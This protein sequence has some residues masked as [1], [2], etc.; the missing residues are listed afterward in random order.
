MNIDLFRPFIAPE[1]A[2]MLASLF[3]PDTDGRL[4]IGQGPRADDLERK[5]GHL[6]EAPYPPLSMASCTAALDMAYEL[7]GI[8]PSSEVITTPITC[9]ATNTNLV[10]R[11]ARLVWADVNPTTGCIDPSDVA[12]K[13]TS[14]TKAIVAVDWAGRS[15]DYAALRR[16]DVPVVEDAAHALL[17]RTKEG[18]IANSGGD[19]VCWSLGPIKHL[20][21]GDGGMLLT[22]KDQHERARLL[23]WYGLDRR[24]SKDF[25]CDQE[26]NEAGTKSHM[27]DI[28]ATIALANL[29]HA[30]R[31][32]SAHRSNA[33]KLHDA[34]DG[35][36]GLTL[37]PFDPYSAH[38]IFTLLVEHRDAF[39]AHMA[40]K[41]IQ[42]SRVHARN[43]KHK[44]LADAGSRNKLPNVVFFDQ[45][46][47]S[48]PCGWWLT[49]ADIEHIL[50][51]VHAWK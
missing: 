6:V 20:S 13:V 4:F 11:G 28:N 12:R 2:T 44:A 37:L 48:L 3:T 23:R 47:V 29:P 34:L 38:W 19:Y 27:N 5:F 35:T 21:G 30:K 41:G 31:I 32:V 24:C 14:R 8:G 45:H 51:A 18:S 39:M 16:H 22:P 43:D 15:C 7:I 49:E 40:A 26:I 17:A 33:R 1:A 42:V 36:K 10:R 50:A 46:Q 25:R 9:V